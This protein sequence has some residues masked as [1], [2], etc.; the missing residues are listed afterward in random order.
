MQEL[1]IVNHTIIYL[2][3]DI[4]YYFKI[5]SEIDVQIDL[6]KRSKYISVQI[7]YWGNHMKND[8]GVNISMYYR[9]LSLNLRL[10]LD[11]PIAKRS[12]HSEKKIA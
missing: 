2:F 10:H 12:W 8:T 9:T 1:C 5:D 4:C 11:N 7:G 6:K 3:I